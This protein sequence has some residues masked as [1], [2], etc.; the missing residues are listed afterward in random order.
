MGYIKK[1][2]IQLILNT[3]KQLFFNNTFTGSGGLKAL[4]LFLLRKHQD[5]KSARVFVYVRA[6]AVI[7]WAKIFSLFCFY[8]FHREINMCVCV[9]MYIA[10]TVLA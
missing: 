2:N 6:L 3:Q 9:F 1:K 4:S 8:E 7:S 10:T 5:G